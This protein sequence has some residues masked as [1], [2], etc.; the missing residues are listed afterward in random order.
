M[1]NRFATNKRPQPG[2]PT[3]AVE[4]EVDREATTRVNFY[5]NYAAYG[6]YSGRIDVPDYIIAEGPSAVSRYI[7][8]NRDDADLRDAQEDSC[9]VDWSDVEVAD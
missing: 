3:A 8:E 7:R 9:E 6:V 5:V 4:D 1:S 2:S